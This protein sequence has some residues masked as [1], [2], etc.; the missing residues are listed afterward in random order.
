MVTLERYVVDAYLPLPMGIKGLSF[1]FFTGSQQAYR[2]VGWHY[3]VSRISQS[4]S[5]KKITDH[6]L[7]F[8]GKG[9]HSTMARSQ[10][11]LFYIVCPRTATIRL[12]S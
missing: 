11:V 4:L 12:Y 1:M 6:V 8:D 9:S 10:F 3:S 5:L 7:E 2:R